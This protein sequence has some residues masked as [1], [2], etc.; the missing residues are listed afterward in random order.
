MTE[1]STSDVD[2]EFYSGDEGDFSASEEEAAQNI[3]RTASV[4]VTEDP[5]EDVSVYESDDGSSLAGEDLEPVPDE[6]GLPFEEDEDIETTGYHLRL[7]AGNLKLFEVEGVKNVGL[8]SFNFKGI[9][10]HLLPSVL[11]LEEDG[12]VSCLLFAFIF[13]SNRIVTIPGSSEPL[14][15]AEIRMVIAEYALKMLD[16]GADRHSEYT[17]LVRFHR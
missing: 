8:I 2:D 9:G 13:I 7:G 5:R 12:C 1:G 3:P 11:R 14:A 4:S 16:P 10:I 17:T 15:R 6:E